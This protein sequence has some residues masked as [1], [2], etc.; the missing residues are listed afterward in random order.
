MDQNNPN[1]LVIIRTFDA[2]LATVWKYF[3]EP[4]LYK[5]WWGPK[6]FTCPEIKMDFRVG[7]KFVGCMR[8]S[9]AEG[10]PVQ[11]FWSTGTYKEIVAPDNNGKAKIVST[12]S[13]ADENG[14]IVPSSHYGMEGMPLEMLVTLEFEE[15]D[16]NPPS[17]GTSAGR[18]TML[19][20]THS[21]IKNIDE[22][23]RAGMDQGW[24]ES[25]D[26][27]DSILKI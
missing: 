5:K 4:E 25:F 22:K 8:G 11:D 17:S 23:S 10:A 3:S 16:G 9:P 12:D 7:G 15:K 19:K 13:F 6:V 20:L 1:E 27:I 18:R 14:N 21:G 26:K 24:N 2:P